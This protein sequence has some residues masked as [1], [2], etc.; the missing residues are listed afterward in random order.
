MIQNIVKLFNIKFCVQRIRKIAEL[1][2][3]LLITFFFFFIWG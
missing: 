2:A 1:A 3:F